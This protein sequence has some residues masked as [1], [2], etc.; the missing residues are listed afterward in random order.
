MDRLYQFWKRDPLAIPL[1]T[2]D[3]LIQKL[4]IFTL[5]QLLK[6]GIYASTL[7]NIGGVAQVF[8]KLVLISLAY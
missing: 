8:M 6:S 7:K 5:T 2:E 4:D 3:V 1:S